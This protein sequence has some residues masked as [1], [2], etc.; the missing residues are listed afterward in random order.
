MSPP[1]QRKPMF[2]SKKIKEIKIRNN[3]IDSE[4]E[5]A[6]KKNKIVQ[7]KK[8]TDK[9][10]EKYLKIVSK[11]RARNTVAFPTKSHSNLLFTKT[12][13]S[14]ENKSNKKEDKLM[15]KV[16]NIE[17]IFEEKEEKQEKQDDENHEE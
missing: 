13:P 1:L 11:F 3:I 12:V 14:K 15:Q 17:E 4:V 5:I 9:D 16:N 10:D 2:L 7:H 6:N 8:E